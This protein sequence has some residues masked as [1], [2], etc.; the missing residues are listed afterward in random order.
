MKTIIK[1][2]FVLLIGMMA[3]S[4][5]QTAQPSTT[6]STTTTTGAQTYMFSYDYKIGTSSTVYSGSECSTEAEMINKQTLY[7]WYNIVKKGKC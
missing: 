7:G 1:L 3:C 6:T 4:K 2:S 5:K